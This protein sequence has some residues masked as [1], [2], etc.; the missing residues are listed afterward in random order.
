ML[1]AKMS[2]LLQRHK[3]AAREISKVYEIRCHLDL[4]CVFAVSLEQ[5]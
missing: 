4:G 1:G 2:E 3:H 5:L